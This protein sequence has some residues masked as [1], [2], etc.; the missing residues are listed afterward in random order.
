MVLKGK[1]NQV[2]FLHIYHHTTISAVWWAIAFAAP[3]GDGRLTFLLNTCGNVC[4]GRLYV[5]V[6]LF[7]YYCSQPS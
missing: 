5:L 4:R 3:G 6:L 2:S 7:V 1:L